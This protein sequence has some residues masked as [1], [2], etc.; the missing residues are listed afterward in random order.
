MAEDTARVKGLDG[1]NMYSEP[2]QVRRGLIQGVII[3]PI[4]FILAL[5]Q[6]FRLYDKDPAGAEVGN[7]LQ[8]GVLG[9]ADDAA[10]SGTTLNSKGVDETQQNRLRVTGRRRHG[11]AQRKSEEYAR[12]CVTKKN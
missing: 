11:A 8:I 4:F 7:Y 2:F 9:Y 3:S 5:E 1:K 6:V 12:T 10:R